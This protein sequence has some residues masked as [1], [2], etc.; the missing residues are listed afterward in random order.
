M[1]LRCLPLAAALTLGALTFG[2]LAQVST[3]P[4]SAASAPTTKAKTGPRLLTPEES[5]ESGTAAG[6]L[7][8]ERQVTPQVSIPLG[9]KP[10]PPTRPKASSGTAPRNGAAAGGINDAAARCEAQ[11]D[12]QARATC[13]DKLAR[14]TRA[15][16]PG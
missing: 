1:K 11:V 16:P 5:R 12:K 8:P 13:R 15:R 4:L 6:D 7:R 9:K 2:A 10:P 3:P 14:E